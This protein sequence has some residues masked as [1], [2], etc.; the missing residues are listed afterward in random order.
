MIAGT[1]GN[2][3]GMSYEG[4]VSDDGSIF[5]MTPS[6]AVTIIYSFTMPDPNTAF[7]TD[8][9]FPYYNYLTEATD[10]TIYGS[11]DD[12]GPHDEGTVFKLA[13]PSLIAS[14]APPAPTPP[15]TTGSGVRFDFDGDGKADLL[16]F[17]TATNRLSVFD[18][19]DTSVVQLGNTFAGPAPGSGWQPVASVDVSGDGFPDLI[20]WNSQTGEL[21]HWTMQGN[22]PLQV[23]GDFATV[24][25]TD[26]K[27]VAAADVV[28]NTAGNPTSWELVFQNTATG[29]I[30]RWTMSGTTVTNYGSD[31]ASLGAGSPWQI[32]GAPDLDGDGKSDLLFW[33]DATGDVSYWSTD[34]AN[35]HVNTVYGSFSQVADTSWHLVGS[36]DTNSD[37][38]SDYIWWNASTGEVSRWLM[39][40]MTVQQYGGNTVD[41]ADTN[42]QPTAIR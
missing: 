12:S 2:F 24:A 38:H 17:N 39:N 14:V 20:W 30:S 32:V 35:S 31:L 9:A 36:E 11:V 41:V 29:E 26:W 34:L 4:G 40:G 27:P 1:D 5:Q 25:D 10:G 18:M 8:G 13:I 21:S 3:Y 7:N 28:D 16:W 23:Y 37:G 33:N 19:D 42:W 22:T 15:T 6:G